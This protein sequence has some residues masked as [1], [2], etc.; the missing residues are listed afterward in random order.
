MKNKMI[1]NKKANVSIMILVLGVVA[2]C[3]LAILSF[4]IS[5]NLSSFHDNSGV[6]VIEKINSDVEKFY[7]YQNVLGEGSDEE[8]A[9]RIGAEFVD[10]KLVII[11]SD[12]NY[13]KMILGHEI[14]PMN[15]FISVKYSL[16]P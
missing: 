14:I 3:G 15:N 10:G 9:K 12:E 6:G 2:I 4:L 8:S 16:V 1:K 11:E 7:F 13:P 5:E